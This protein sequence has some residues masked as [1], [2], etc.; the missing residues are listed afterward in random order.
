M[1]ETTK[2]VVRKTDEYD[3]FK[4]MDANRSIDPSHV[5]TL[6]NS[7]NEHGVLINP[8]LVN[9][10]MQVVDGQNRL[11]ACR[12][13]G[14]PI[15]YLIVDDYGI[16]EVQALNLNQKNWTQQDYAES[17]AS[18]G[19]E[20][21]ENLLKFYNDYDEFNLSSCVKLLQNS[22]AARNIAQKRAR[23][24]DSDEYYNFKQVFEEGT[25]QIRDYSKAELWADYLRKI[26]EYYSGYNRSSFVN[27]MIGLFNKKQFDVDEF[28]RKLSYQSNSLNDCTRVGDYLLLI[29]EIYNFKK[30][31]KVNLRF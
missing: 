10:K 31:D 27:T 9:N 1:I 28:L 3:L 30:R 15:Y 26:G 23:T 22:T 13:V 7:I 19:Y 20:H 24:S 2:Y 25:W 29:E 5:K 12:Q 21:Y 4:L 6:K 17:F 11:E 14:E 16:K 8:I 18:M